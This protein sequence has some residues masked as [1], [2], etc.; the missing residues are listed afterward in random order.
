[1]LGVQDSLIE[2]VFGIEGDTGMAFEG[3]LGVESGTRGRAKSGLGSNILKGNN[4]TVGGGCSRE[5]MA[6]GLT[7]RFP[8]GN[9]QKSSLGEMTV[10]C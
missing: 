1:M 5:V 3:G 8:E 9:T 10:L 7:I 2:A 6:V 4:G